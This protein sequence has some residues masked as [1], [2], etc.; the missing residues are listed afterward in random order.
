MAINLNQ[1]RSGGQ[2][3]GQQTGGNVDTDIAEAITIIKMIA[4]CVA[5]L[6]PDQQA[7]SSGDLKFARDQIVTSLSPSYRIT[8]RQLFYLRDIKDKLVEAGIL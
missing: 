5:Q 8:G 1:N 4:P 3:L 7:L 6:P 2:G